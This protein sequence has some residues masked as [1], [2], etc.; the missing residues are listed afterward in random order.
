[1]EAPGRF[2]FHAGG[3]PMNML[4]RRSP[5][6]Q[7]GGPAGGTERRWRVRIRKLHPLLRQLINVRRF[8]KIAAVARKIRPAGRPEFRQNHNLDNPSP[9]LLTGVEP[10]YQKI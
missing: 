4:P 6:G 2:P 7:D 5:A 9:T 10:E 3:H 1:M 8:I